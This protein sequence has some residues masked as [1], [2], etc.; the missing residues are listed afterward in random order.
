MK[1]IKKWCDVPKI[2]IDSYHEN[3]NQ[4]DSIELLQAMKSEKRDVQFKRGF[5]FKHNIFGSKEMSCEVNND[6]NNE[7][8]SQ[9]TKSNSLGFNL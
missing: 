5:S 7:R 1:N 3:E 2:K 6:N 9:I 4:K 8:V